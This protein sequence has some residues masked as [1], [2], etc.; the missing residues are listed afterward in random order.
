MRHESTPNDPRNAD[1]ASELQD[2]MGSRYERLR[3]AFPL[4]TG[5]PVAWTKTGAPLVEALRW[6]SSSRLGLFDLDPQATQSEIPV[7]GHR[8]LIGFFYRRSVSLDPAERPL[9][10][11]DPI[12]RAAFEELIE[13]ELLNHVLRMAFKVNEE[14]ANLKDPDPDWVPDAV[15]ML[16]RLGLAVDRTGGRKIGVRQPVLGML[17][18]ESQQIVGAVREWK[19]DRDTLRVVG[20]LAGDASDLDGERLQSALRRGQISKTVHD[21]AASVAFP[22]LALDEIQVIRKSSGVVR[23]AAGLIHSR[24]NCDVALSYLERRIRDAMKRRVSAT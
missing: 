7:R 3:E 13:S 23:T 9:I 14:R 16:N 10:T 4:W 24:L 2:L 15:E 18:G 8:A 21:L 22:F 17:G 12:V 19:I 11:D 5:D 20:L 1:L 6:S